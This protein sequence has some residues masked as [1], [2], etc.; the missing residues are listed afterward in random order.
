MDRWE[1]RVALVW[2]ADLERTLNE[3]GEEGWDAVTVTRE[4]SV[5]G[6]VMGKK[7]F[8]LVLKRPYNLKMLP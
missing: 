4:G 5:K 2:T 7:L 1:Y 6:A 3:A 8:R